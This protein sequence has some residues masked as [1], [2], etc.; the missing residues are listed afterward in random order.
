MIAPKTVPKNQ[1]SSN[2]VFLFIY[3]FFVLFIAKSHILL[4]IYMSVAEIFLF[5]YL[6]SDSICFSLHY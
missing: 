3:G 2:L 6:K 1:V 5:K 4:K